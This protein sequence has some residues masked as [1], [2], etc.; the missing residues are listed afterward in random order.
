MGSGN[1]LIKICP[2]FR[3]NVLTPIA[4]LSGKNICSEWESRINKSF[5][6]YCNT[7]PKPGYWYCINTVENEQYLNN[8]R[9]CCTSK[10]HAL[11][12][13]FW[14]FIRSAMSYLLQSFLMDNNW[15]TTQT[16]LIQC[17]RRRHILH[18][19]CFGIVL[20]KWSPGIVLVLY[21]SKK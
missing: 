11:L 17:M 2:A 7:I 9:K 1:S 21:C 15:L 14:H 18:W 12:N 8:T 4:D 19:Y 16:Y 10:A 20:Q 5:F 3:Q 13:R 6:L